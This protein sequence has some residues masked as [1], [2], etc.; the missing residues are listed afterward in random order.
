[1]FL[2]VWRTLVRVFRRAVGRPTRRDKQREEIEDNEEVAETGSSIE[3]VAGMVA[4]PEDGT[5]TAEEEE[6]VLALTL[7]LKMSCSLE[8]REDL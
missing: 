7:D 4:H 6:G 2:S 3:A 8:L 1:M 5:D